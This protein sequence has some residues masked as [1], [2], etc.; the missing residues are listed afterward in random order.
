M[1]HISTAER[2]AWN[3]RMY[4]RYP[5]PHGN[6]LLRLIQNARHRAVKDFAAIQSTDR[7]LEIGCEAGHLLAAMPT[8][9]LLVG[10]D[11]CDQALL[12]AT[13]RLK[14]TGSHALFL[15]T[16]AEEPLPFQPPNDW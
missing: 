2:V 12:D 6:A 5:T 7:V 4:R 13:A 14:D 10:V 15:Q 9:G 16:D 1:T 8:P 11:I 3:E